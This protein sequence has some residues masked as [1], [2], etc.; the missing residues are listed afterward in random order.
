MSSNAIDNIQKSFNDIPAKAEYGY[1]IISS[2]DKNS[3]TISYK[4]Y[5]F[6]GNA[7]HSGSKSLNIGDSADLDGDGIPDIVY[8]KPS[9]SR[10]GIND[11]VYL[12]FICSEDNLTTAMY[13]IIKDQ[14]ANGEYPSGIIGINPD[15]KFII[16][17]YNSSGSSKSITTGVLKGDFVYDSTTGT[18]SKT[19]VNISS[20]AINDSD[21][22][23]QNSQN[24]SYLF[25]SSQFSD[26]QTPI[27][28]YSDLPQSVKDIYGFATDDSMALIYLNNCLSDRGLIQKCSTIS[29]MPIP[30]TELSY[31]ISEIPSLSAE[32]L[33]KLNRLFFDNAFPGDCPQIDNSSTDITSVL[34][35]LNCVFGN[36]DLNQL[37]G[38]DATSKSI[39]TKSLTSSSYNTDSGSILSSYS[40]YTKIKSFDSF[41]ISNDS[42][43]TINNSGLQIGYR[44]S[45]GINASSVSSH[46]DVALLLQA[47]TNITI[48][49]S[50]S[51][52][53]FNYTVPLGVYSIPIYGPII[54]N[55][56]PKLQANIPLSV[57]CGT[58]LT[59]TAR[60]AFIGM[61]GAGFN[62]GANWGINWSHWWIFSYP[63]PYFNPSGNGYLISQ[64]AYYCGCSS[65][66]DVTFNGAS[67]SLDPNVSFGVNVNISS[68]IY[69][70]VNTGVG[71]NNQLGIKLNSSS[72]LVGTYNVALNEYVTADAGV[73]LSLPIIGTVGYKWTWPLVNATQNLANWQVF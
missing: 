23:S 49:A 5:D 44:G 54:I 7:V 41:P 46:L 61:Y 58:S 67:V 53:L 17:K 48:T 2:I 43:L 40:S 20:R 60:L 33:L 57:S 29:N 42:K 14:Y 47:D 19:I 22:S 21:I 73:G 13:S 30:A 9:K 38:S 39:V 35:Y 3:I 52:N 59:N 1:L 65:T 55:I 31:V 56:V 12:R 72:I 10:T 66:R 34:P 6:N 63:H 8:Q 70:D 37:Q 28:L 50:Y 68:I 51:K 15:E 24:I 36:P 64:T 62:A 18:F 11:A 69:G 25:T 27:A 26:N 4:I 45:F 16:S 71:L 32:D